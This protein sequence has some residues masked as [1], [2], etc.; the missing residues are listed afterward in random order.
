MLKESKSPIEPIRIAQVMGKMLGGGV[1]AVVMNYYRHIDRSRVQ[2][3]FLVDADSTR[4]PRDEIEFL[5]GRGIIIN[6]YQK[7]LSYQR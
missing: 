3:D 4:V 6:P 5:G 1:E 2:F 7:P